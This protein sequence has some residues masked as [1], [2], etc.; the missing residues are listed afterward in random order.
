MLGS[1]RRLCPLNRLHL[2]PGFRFRDVEAFN[3]LPIF[4]IPRVS[5]GCKPRVETVNKGLV[6]LQRALC[7]ASRIPS[8]A[9]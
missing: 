4:T 6:P 8:Q 9:E 7:R 1:L 5:T 3:A 2:I